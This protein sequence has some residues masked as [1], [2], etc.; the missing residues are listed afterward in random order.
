M[1]CLFDTDITLKLSACDLLQPALAVLGANKNEVYVLR[2]EAYRVYSCNQD[3]KAAYPGKRSK[4]RF[5][6]YQSGASN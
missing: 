3:L 2:E 1:T 4:K 6:I 5:E